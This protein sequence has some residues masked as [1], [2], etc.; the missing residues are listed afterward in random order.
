MSSR[1]IAR[2]ALLAALL[3]LAGCGGIPGL[4]LDFS[5]SDHVSDAALE[6]A[7]RREL[8]E[9]QQ[10][11]ADAT[12]A[13]AAYSMEQALQ[14]QG[15]AHA[16]VDFRMLPPVG[17]L[18]HASFH[19]TEGPRVYL[20]SLHFPGAH[21]FSED[22]LRGAMQ[23]AGIGYFQLQKPPYRETD[24]ERAAESIESLYLLDGYYRVK[25]DPAVVTFNASGAT[26]YA[27]M[28]ISEGRYYTISTVAYDFD[29]SDSGMSRK[30]FALVLAQQDLTGQAY[31]ARL[32]SFTQSRIQSWLADHGHLNGEVTS[33]VQIN[34][35]TGSVVVSF[36][37][38][39]GPV[40]VM[41]HLIISGNQHTRASF[42]TKSIG[43]TPGK[44][45][46]Q[47]SVDAGLLALSRSG[48][49]TTVRWKPMPVTDQGQDRPT[50]VEV[51][52]LEAKAKTVDFEAGYG[53][54]E[55]LRAGIRYQDRN[56]FG[57]GR[58]LEIH[59][60]VSMKGYAIAGRVRDNYL[61]GH[62]NTLELSSSYMYRKQ[63]TY[64]LYLIQATLSIEHRFNRMLSMRGGYTYE[65][66]KATDNQAPIL[67]IDGSSY[68][69]APRL[70]DTIRYDRRDSPV[71]P[72]RGFLGTAGIAY[73]SK[74]LG[75]ELDFL[76]YTGSATQF[77]P[78]SAKAV[79]GL[80]ATYDTRQLLDAAETLPVQ[81]RLFLGGENSVRSYRE[82]MLSPADDTGALIGGLTAAMANA[83]LRLQ[84]A[85]SVYIA[86]FYDIGEV[87]TYTWRLDGTVG[88]AIGT[89]FRYQLPVGPV[90]FDLA[91]NPQRSPW[92]THGYMGQVAVGFSF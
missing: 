10:H 44:P 27:V 20:G 2:I 51:T 55:E 75:S 82:M 58:Y 21:H 84:V 67:G 81:E 60:T 69:P 91:Y 38:V 64:N 52:V 14:Q 36:T 11:P 53:S 62:T 5:G 19:I 42:I 3:C 88:Q 79:L 49:F 32:P 40:F 54:Y 37:I 7:A 71:D 45:I 50:D 43:L 1:R 16:H 72:T 56:L 31:Y 4:K 83:E 13:D 74:Y 68:I 70:F 61:L 8:T 48:A 65:V 34:D 85:G 73:S 12:L 25:I 39:A 89:G 6:A 26:A 18:Q 41:R 87:S 90:R 17:S 23:A 59:P 24:L 92:T 76:E 86:F 78:L 22:K 47:D 46:S 9:Y 28:P 30:D 63:P 80:N 29:L 57:A 35:V 77:F 33:R 15:F 66:E